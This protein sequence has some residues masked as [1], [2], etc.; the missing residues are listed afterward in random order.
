V[1]DQ[2]INA[3]ADLFSQEIHSTQYKAL[4]K[5]LVN[6]L[7]DDTYM[8]VVMED[9]KIIITADPEDILDSMDE[10]IHE[11]TADENLN[12]SIDDYILK[13]RPNVSAKTEVWLH[14][15]LNQYDYAGNDVSNSDLF[16]VFSDKMYEIKGWEFDADL[17][18][19]DDK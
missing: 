17:S 8:S 9:H 13:S 3:Y 14:D 4:V 12:F 7:D 6:D 11:E 19:I 18:Y 5:T 15:I 10:R 1:R 16:E 2:L